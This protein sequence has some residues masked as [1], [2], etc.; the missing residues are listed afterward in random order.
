MNNS[1]RIM[2]VDDHAIVREGYRALLQ[3][4]VNFEVIAEACDGAEAYTL[5]KSHKPDHSDC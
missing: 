1:I 3:K 2:L 5:Y 4:Q